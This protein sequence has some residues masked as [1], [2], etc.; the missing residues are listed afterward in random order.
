M[1]VLGVIGAGAVYSGQC[2]DTYMKTY[3]LPALEYCKTVVLDLEML[4][5]AWV[6][7]NA[8]SGIPEFSVVLE[9]LQVVVADC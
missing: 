9:A 4:Y 3:F 2:S 5:S 6:F 1:L 7:S 8:P